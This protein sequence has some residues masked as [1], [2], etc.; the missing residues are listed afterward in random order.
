MLSDMCTW[1]PS[2]ECI[3][4]MSIAV[5][6]KIIFGSSLKLFNRRRAS[7]ARMLK[8][9]HFQS[10]WLLLLE[11]PKDLS[12]QCSTL[13]QRCNWPSQT[14]REEKLLHHQSPNWGHTRAQLNDSPVSKHWQS[15]IR[16]RPQPFFIYLDYR[17]ICLVLP[18][19]RST[20]PS[21]IRRQQRCSM[22]CQVDLPS[23]RCPEMGFSPVFPEGQQRRW[24][25]YK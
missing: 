10:L 18:W 1:P 2:M 6:Q 15:Q 19:P 17:R 11:W 12:K 22:S 7:T 8:G 24:C 13:P 25:R 9:R 3:L 21:R 14:V 5:E 20:E 4:A 23:G 16:R